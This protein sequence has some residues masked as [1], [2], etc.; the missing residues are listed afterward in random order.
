MSMYL[1]NRQSKLTAT[2]D[3][4]RISAAELSRCAP[5]ACQCL[6]EQAVFCKGIQDPDSFHLRLHP[7]LRPP[8][9]VL[10]PVCVAAE[11]RGRGHMEGFCGPR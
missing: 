8:S 10:E 1:Y 5:G 7:F 3:S 9:S 11:G 6:F 4:S 2:S